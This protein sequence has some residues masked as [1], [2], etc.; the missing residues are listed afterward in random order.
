MIKTIDK[1]L[2]NS[3][4]QFLK[5]FA[6]D[7]VDFYTLKKLGN[8]FIHFNCQSGNENDMKNVLGVLWVSI[9]SKVKTSL[10]NITVSLNLLYF[11]N[12]F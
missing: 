10:R 7:N 1:F 2:N 5:S 12:L 9:L 11:L 4:L 3:D 8:S 6:N